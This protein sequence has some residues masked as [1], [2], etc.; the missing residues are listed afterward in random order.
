[1]N[2]EA[3]KVYN[4]SFGQT[5]PLHLLRKIMCTRLLKLLAASCMLGSVS[6]AEPLITALDPSP[7]TCACS[8][9]LCAIAPPARML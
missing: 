9:R 1:M 2:D 4:H 3:P 7:T 5:K 6:A 8:A